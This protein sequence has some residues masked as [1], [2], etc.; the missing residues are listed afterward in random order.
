MSDLL[1]QV[2]IV[3]AFFVSL[4]IVGPIAMALFDRYYGAYC[5]WV[6]DKLL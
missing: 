3:I 4:A 2:G 6:F 1:L 5:D